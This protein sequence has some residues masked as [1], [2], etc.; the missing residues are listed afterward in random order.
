MRTPHLILKELRHRK[1][2]F[3]LSLLGVVGAVALFVFFITA[4]E[5]SRRE[6]ARLAR[7]MGLNLRIIPRQTDMDRYW[8]RGFSEQTMPEDS[9][10]Q[11]ASHTGLNYAHLLPTLKQRIEWRDR[12]VILVG[13]LPEISPA[14]RRESPMSLTVPQ[15]SV[16]VGHELARGL[17]L[18]KGALIELLGRRFA[19]ASCLP[20]SGSDQD[21]SIFGHLRD[22]QGLVRMEGRI[23]EIQALN[24]ICFDSS[25]N[26]LEMLREQLA[27]A[28]PNTQVI[29]IRPIAEAR[30]KQRRMVEDYLAVAVPFVLV[31]CAA[32]L[33]LLAMINVRERRQEIGILRAMGYGSGKIASLFLGKAVAIG[34][35]GAV[36]GFAVGTGLALLYGPGIFKVTGKAIEPLYSLLAESAVA[37][38]AFAA[39]ATMIPTML[40]VTQDP[41][42]AL[43]ED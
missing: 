40:A 20:E 13:I 18:K 41:A 5:A 3:L 11:L 12:D 10:K 21:I 7:D 32:W 6:T 22:V 17:G 42:V 15:G 36:V 9:A 2:G 33:C 23:N 8:S 37:A 43:R 29:Q 16:C 1:S 31:I 35:L 28:L 38:P 39:V 24:C 25:R 19:V 4:G 14:D 34:V 30:E 27:R 26:A